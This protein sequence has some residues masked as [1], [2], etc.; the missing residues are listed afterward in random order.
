MNDK[1]GG[2]TKLTPEDLKFE[3]CRPI[4]DET[5]WQLRDAMR[6]MILRQFGIPPVI[7]AQQRRERRMK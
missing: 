1:A 7:L 6:D 4:T 5:W 3:E 2:T